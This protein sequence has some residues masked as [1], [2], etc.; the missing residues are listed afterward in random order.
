MPPSFDSLVK[1]IRHPVIVRLDDGDSLTG[2]LLNVDPH[3]LA[4]ILVQNGSKS[5]ERSPDSEDEDGVDN[6][7]KT[8]EAN[9][10]FFV[11]MGHAIVDIE[12]DQYPDEGPEA[13]TELRAQALLDQRSNK[14]IGSAFASAQ[15]AINSLKAWMQKNNLTAFCDEDGSVKVINGA[16]TISPPY[17]ATCVSSGNEILAELVRNLV[18]QWESSS[19]QAGNKPTG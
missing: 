3:T 12:A 2:Y 8:L 17:T 19:P 5:D 11:I 7:P 9:P 14:A 18:A 1:H 10:K 15:H 6:P 13:L 16:V 4:V